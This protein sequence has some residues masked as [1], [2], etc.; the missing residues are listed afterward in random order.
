MFLV[1]SSR[2]RRLGLKTIGDQQAMDD[3]LQK[4]HEEAKQATSEAV[5]KREI[6][7]HSKLISFT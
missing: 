4:E 7:L 6:E 5:L 3:R 1:K 2:R